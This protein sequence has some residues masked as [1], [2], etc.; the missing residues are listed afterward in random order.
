MSAGIPVLGSL[1]L[2]GAVSIIR[3][4][5]DYIQEHQIAGKDG[6]LVERV[7]SDKTRYEIKG[8]F[9]ESGA[10]ASYHTLLGM[11]GTTQTLSIPTFNPAFPFVKANSTC[12]VE[13]AAANWMPG[14]GYPRYDYDIKIVFQ[15]PP[16]TLVQFNAGTFATT[17]FGVPLSGAVASGNEIV[18]VL[19]AR[20]VT[21]GESAASGVFSDSLASIYNFDV[22]QWIVSG[23]AEVIIA[24]TLLS[25]G[26]AFAVSGTVKANW[27]QNS[28]AVYELQGL[29]NSGP[30]ATFQGNPACGAPFQATQTAG[31]ITFSAV[32]MRNT[33][34]V[35][36]FTGTNDINDGLDE[37][38]GR[39]TGSY[40]LSNCAGLVKPIEYGEAS[41]T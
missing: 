32:A 8:M 2:S 1:T 9:Y 29:A 14:Y 41:Y 23:Q 7:G 5:H 36:T 38:I 33:G 37:A 27:T 35:L 16:V 15:A 11:S 34:G 12:F 22:D 3:K 21:P 40:S 19:A 28:F 39:G 26:G 10:D 30:N 6:G 20:S 18:I 25:A 13:Y 17:T 4:E 31:S 24:H